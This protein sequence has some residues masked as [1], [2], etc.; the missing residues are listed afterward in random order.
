MIEPDSYT[1]IP[2]NQ[3]F[4]VSYHGYFIANCDTLKEAE[5]EITE[6]IEQIKNQNRTQRKENRTA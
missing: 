3:Y 2:K 6:H 4:A 1:I 5:Q